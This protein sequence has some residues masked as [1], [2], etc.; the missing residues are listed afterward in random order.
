MKK[1]LQRLITLSMAL[2]ILISSTGFGLIEHQCM[3]RGKSLQLLSSNT[4]SCKSCKAPA[5]KSRYG[6]NDTFFK[7][8]DCCKD[9]SRHEKLEVVSSASQMLAKFFKALAE[10]VFYNLKLYTFAFAEWIAPSSFDAPSLTFSSLLHGRS[11]LFF[12]QSFLI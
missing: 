3:M 7:K 4:K 10:A 8:A 12:I 2:M 9:E 5:Q 11:M 6:K 1:A